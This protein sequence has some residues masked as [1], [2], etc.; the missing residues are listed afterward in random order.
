MSVGDIGYPSVR[1][2]GGGLGRAEELW[3]RQLGLDG[4]SE[5]GRARSDAVR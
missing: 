5:E 3:Y 4:S 1:V 2:I